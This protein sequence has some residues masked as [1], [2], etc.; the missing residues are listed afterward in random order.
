MITIEF[1]YSNSSA[2]TRAL[3]LGAGLNSF[4]QVANGKQIFFQCNLNREDIKFAMPFIEA[5]SKLKNK[6]VTVDGVEMDWKDA[7]KFNASAAK[8]S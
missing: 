7:F 4:E 6:S 8:F 3:E 2:C 1:L 5:V